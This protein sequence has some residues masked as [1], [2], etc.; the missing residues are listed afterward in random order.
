MTQDRD[1]SIDL[2]LPDLAATAA[3]DAAAIRA[4]QPI[5][6]GA[7]LEALKIFQVVDVIVQH[8]LDGALPLDGDAA[9]GIEQDV[10][11]QP[12]HLT[13]QERRAVYARTLGLPGGNADEPRPNREFNDLWLRFLASVSTL[14]RQAG[15]TNADIPQLQQAVRKTARDLAVNLSLHGYGI[16]LFVAT[17]LQSE[18]QTVIRLLSTHEIRQAFGARNLWQ[19]IDQVATLE[20]GGAA[21]S[22]QARTL[23]TS[24]AVVIAWLAERASA[25][26]SG[27]EPDL[28]HLDQLTLPGSTTPLATP[29]DR[30]LVTACEDWLSAA[31]LT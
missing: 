13:E 15:S 10:R 2:T 24:G 9:A 30:D 6:V 29:T 27:Q 14:V 7:Q 28:L 11:T 5:Y 25:L 22:R 31:S 1:L 18:I 8:V 19:V 26:T 20:L 4:I 12:D 16:G 21:N 3:P 23:A 17:E